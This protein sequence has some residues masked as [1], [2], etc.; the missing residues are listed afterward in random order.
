MPAEFDSAQDSLIPQTPKEG[1]QMS[2]GLDI[3]YL[4]TGVLRHR[5]QVVQHSLAQALASM[6]REQSDPREH[7]FCL[8]AVRNPRRSNRL[9][10][11]ENQDMHRRRI[12]AVHVDFVGEPLLGLQYDLSNSLDL[13]ELVSRSDLLD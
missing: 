1:F 13:P 7:A 3:D 12:L 10:S 5:L 9:A 6:R 2:M 4:E 8:G 11:I